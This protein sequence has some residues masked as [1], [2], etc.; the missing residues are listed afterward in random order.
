MIL[1]L[2]LAAQPV[3]ALTVTSE[4]VPKPL[5]GAREILSPALPRNAWSVFHVHV[6]GPAGTAYR[7]YV[8]Q[9]PEDAV[10]AKLFDGDR[11]IETP[12]EAKLPP[13]SPASY[14]L[15]IFSSANDEVR[16]IKVEPQVYIEPAG[17]IVYPMEVR[18]V[19]ARVPGPA[20]NRTPAALPAEPALRARFCQEPATAAPRSVAQDLAIAAARPE[21]SVREAFARALGTPVEKWCLHPVAPGNP[22][23]FLEFRDWLLR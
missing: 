2:A 18:I 23:W 7:L 9:N 11:E 6:H 19:A 22:E 1:L 5:A 10:S 17:W 3:P 21:A 14:R 16:R 8:G 13:E 4:F 12:V 20:L 15:E